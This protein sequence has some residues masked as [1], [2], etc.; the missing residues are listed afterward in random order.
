MSLVWKVSLQWELRLQF[1]VPLEAGETVDGAMQH[2][3]RNW[4]PEDEGNT[5]ETDVLEWTHPL[6]LRF[7]SDFSAPARGF[8]EY[9]Y[10]MK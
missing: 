9:D 2:V 5:I 10:E 3:A 4:S 1:W 8:Q 7:P 6:R